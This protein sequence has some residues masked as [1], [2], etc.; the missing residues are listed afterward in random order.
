MKVETPPIG[1]LKEV[2]GDICKFSLFELERK[3][4]LLYGYYL[5]YSKVIIAYYVFL[6][7][8]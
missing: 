8:Y 6:L 3:F 7:L 5:H 1:V 4:L 2:G